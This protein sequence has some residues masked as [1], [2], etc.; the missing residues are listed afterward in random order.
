[1]TSFS[2]SIHLKKVRR[3]I[4]SRFL[5]RSG[6]IQDQRLQVKGVDSYGIILQ[7]AFPQAIISFI[8]AQEYGLHA[9]VLSTA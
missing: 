7:A 8:F 6:T 4:F 2:K 1:L 9:E 3:R 5:I